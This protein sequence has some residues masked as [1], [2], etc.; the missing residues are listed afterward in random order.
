MVAR[1]AN[2]PIPMGKK[3]NVKLRAH[4][5]PGA[6]GELHLLRRTR[7]RPNGRPACRP[8]ALHRGAPSWTRAT[9]SGS[10]MAT[11]GATRVLGTVSLQIGTPNVFALREGDLLV[12]LSLA[13]F[14]GGPGGEARTPSRGSARRR[15]R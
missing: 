12:K 9:G 14:D 15:R 2:P 6:R 7:T 10:A 3:A 1:I 13:P 5:V 8:S 11:L 4:V